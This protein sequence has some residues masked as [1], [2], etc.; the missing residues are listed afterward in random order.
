MF[1][2]FAQVTTHQGLFRRWCLRSAARHLRIVGG[3]EWHKDLELETTVHQI[4]IKGVAQVSQFTCQ[5]LPP[6]TL[7]HGPLHFQWV[8]HSLGPSFFGNPAGIEFCHAQIM[9]IHPQPSPRPAHGVSAPKAY[10]QG[11][12]KLVEAMIGT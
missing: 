10:L 6:S 5:Q 12:I 3:F 9:S 7:V 1:F 11:C 2:G 4:N 8:N